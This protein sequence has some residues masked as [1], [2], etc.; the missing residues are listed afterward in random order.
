MLVYVIYRHLFWNRDVPCYAD[1]NQLYVSFSPADE[2]GQSDAIAAMESCVSDKEMDA[3]K[4]TL[5]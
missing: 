1:D 2:N 4:S 5:D 3:R